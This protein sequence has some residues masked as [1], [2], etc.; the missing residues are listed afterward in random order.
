MAKINGVAPSAKTISE[1]KYPVSRKLYQ[2]TIGTPK[3][4]ARDFILFE[5]AKDG[6]K[7]AVNAGYVPLPESVRAASISSLK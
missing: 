6:Q 5:L 2:Y 1:G 7:L 3:G 4:L